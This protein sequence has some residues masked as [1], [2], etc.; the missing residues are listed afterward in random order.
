MQLLAEGLGAG[1]LPGLTT[2]RIIG[3]NVGD[4]AQALRRSP[5]PWAEAPCRDS[6]TILG[7][8]YAAIGDGASGG[9]HDDL[10]AAARPRRESPGVT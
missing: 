10:A 8:S 1:V 4:T 7:L 6:I 2:L 5:P 3:M 9:P